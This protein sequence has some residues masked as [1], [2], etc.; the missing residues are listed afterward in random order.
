MPAW[1]LVTLIALAWLGADGTVRLK[2]GAPQAAH[3]DAALLRRGDI[4]A[5]APESFRATL[6]LTAQPGKERHEIEVW[7]SGG[8]KTLVRMLDPKERGKFLL[9]LG[10][11]MWFISPSAKKPVKLNASYRL[12]GGATLDEVLGVRLSDAYDIESTARQTSPTGEE[13][14]V[15]TLRARRPQQLFQQVRYVLHAATARPVSATYR[16][17]SGKDAT[18]VEFVQWSEGSLVYAKRL[19]VRDLLRKG[20]ATE[21]DVLNIDPRAV[22]ADDLFRLDDGAARRALEAKTP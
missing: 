11:D 12:Y 6:A 19:V 7:R 16:V 18:T 15:F 9:R 14:V 8:A 4:G 5:F 2:A 13:H 3:P 10:D 1:T 21:I 17:R 20:A 22:V